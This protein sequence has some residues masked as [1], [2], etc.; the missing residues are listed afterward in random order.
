MTSK[1]P[2]GPERRERKSLEDLTRKEESLTKER[3]LDLTS[4][5]QAKR[6]ETPVGNR[7]VLE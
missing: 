4:K 7:S 3:I 2:L 6:L 1:N 5:H